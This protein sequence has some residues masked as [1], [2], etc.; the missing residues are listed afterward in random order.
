MI[1]RKMIATAQKVLSA[2]NKISRKMDLRLKM[3]SNGREQGYALY[4][5]KYLGMKHT[6]MVAFSESRGSDS[7]VVYYGTMEDFNDQGNVPTEYLY[8]NRML[9]RYDDVDGAAKFII[10]HLKSMG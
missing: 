5:S 1:S 10:E 2:A 9:F 4:P 3:Y 6:P 8:S 7:I